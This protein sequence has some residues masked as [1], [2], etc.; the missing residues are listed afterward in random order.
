M[1]DGQTLVILA[2]LAFNFMVLGL[3]SKAL[4]R[5]IEN[6]ALAIR[7]QNNYYLQDLRNKISKVI[8]IDHR[9]LDAIIFTLDGADDLLIRTEKRQTDDAKFEEGLVRV[10]NY[11]RLLNIA[12]RTKGPAQSSM[13]D[14]IL[15]KPWLIGDLEE[16]ERDDGKD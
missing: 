3:V 5:K 1:V 2:F 12:L 8:A 13:I 11:I 14:Q 10:R 9:L 6:E 7:S 16:V 15:G 4:Y